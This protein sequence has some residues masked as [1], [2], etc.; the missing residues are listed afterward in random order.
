MSQ[1]IP[2]LGRSNV[3]S[4]MINMLDFMDYH[5]TEL[6]LVEEGNSSLGLKAEVSLPFM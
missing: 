4:D 6:N 2:W 3:V 5:L 1:T